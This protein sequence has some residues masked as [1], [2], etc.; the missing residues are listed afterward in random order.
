MSRRVL[1]R[2]MVTV[3]TPHGMIA[4]KVARFEGRVVNVSPEYEDCARLGARNRIAVSS[5]TR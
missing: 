4:V 3:G 2:E 5:D 1:D